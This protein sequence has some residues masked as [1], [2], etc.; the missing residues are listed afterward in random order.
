VFYLALTWLSE[1]FFT[2]LM[3]RFSFGQ[4]TLGGSEAAS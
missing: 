3:A 4:A 1:K 2:K